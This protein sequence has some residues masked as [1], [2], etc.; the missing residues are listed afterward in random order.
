[1]WSSPMAS[2]TLSLRTTTTGR[3]PVLT[4]GRVFD[5]RLN[6][7]AEFPI[8]AGQPT[9]FELEP[10][11]YTFQSQLPSG[12]AIQKTARIQEG[13]NLVELTLPSSAHKWLAWS[14]VAGHVP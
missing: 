12:K 9:S 1:M 6:T 10:G 11:E 8:T 14:T 7:V 13:Q 5:S 4:N 3:R 2:V